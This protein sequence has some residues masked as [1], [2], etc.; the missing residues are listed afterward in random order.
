MTIKEIYP[1]LYFIKFK[2]Q[3]EVALTFLRVQEYY[4]SQF[5]DIYN[6]YFPLEDY[7]DN[8]AKRYGNF[9]YLSDWNGF[10]I[11][12]DIYIEWADL[13]WNYPDMLNK[14]IN[15]FN[16]IRPIIKKKKSK[17]YLIAT[18]D[19]K[20][21]LNH[22]IAHGLYYLNKNYRNRINKFLNPKTQFY[23]TFK[24]ELIKIGYNDNVITDEIQAYSVTSSIKTLGENDYIK[25]SE[26]NAN[27]I[28]EMGKVFKSYLKK[29][30]MDLK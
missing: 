5:K 11:P 3:Y 17:F 1:G 8:Y 24:K 2:T 25:F 16:K 20:G 23:K 4:E 18:A 13:F 14:E 28:L 7:M 22:E 19:T 12:G 9:T 30:K 27:R 6:K 26:K 15:L 29:V 10:N 21:V